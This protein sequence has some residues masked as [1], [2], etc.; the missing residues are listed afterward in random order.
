MIKGERDYPEELFIDDLYKIHNKVELKDEFTIGTRI[1]KY[2]KI[3]N[4]QQITINKKLMMELRDKIDA[5]LYQNGIVSES[6]ED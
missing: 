5:M 3:L 4:V 2:G 1:T 6:K